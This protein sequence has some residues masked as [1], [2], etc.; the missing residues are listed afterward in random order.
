MTPI[1]VDLTADMTSLVETTSVILNPISEGLAGI[2]AYVFQK[3]R[4]YNVVTE[5]ELEQLAKSTREKFQNTP[6]ENQNFSN[7]KFVGKILE[8]SIYQLD[9]E[10]FRDIYSSLISSSCDRS[11][12]VKPYYSSIIREMS[13][14]DALLLNYFFKNNYLFEV[15]LSSNNQF[16]SEPTEYRYIWK[17]RYFKQNKS[18]ERYIFRNYDDKEY[19]ANQYLADRDYFEHDVN[20][21]L[22]FLV[23]KGIVEESVAEKS[24]EYIPSI[25]KYV[26][27]TDDAA[28][29]FIKQNAYTT[30]K[31][32]ISAETKVYAL[33]NLGIKLK[34]LLSS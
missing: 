1:K 5:I 30:P 19:M 28:Q 16:F 20:Q 32:E 8:D 15:E 14:D 6:L 17:K 10:V 22:T 29:K 12:V 18:S 25:E 24:H 27:D 11:K 3:P 4:K 34:E 9:N 26:I 23:S 13:N 31:V 21:E 7:I 33:S 2:F